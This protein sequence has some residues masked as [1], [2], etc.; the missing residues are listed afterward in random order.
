MKTYP[1]ML[2]AFLLLLLAVT[3]QANDLQIK[4]IL[5]NTNNLVYIPGT[6]IVASSAISNTTYTSP[7]HYYLASYLNN[8]VR[9]LV[10][11]GQTPLS[12]NISRSGSYHTIEVSQRLSN[13]KTLLVFTRGDWS[14]VENRIALIEQGK[15]L[16]S[17]IPSFAHGL[18]IRY[19]IKLLLDYYNDI[20]LQS[21]MI[22]QSGSHELE[23]E[24]N[25]TGTQKALII[26]KK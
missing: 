20:D 25:K 22:I 8:L 10:H 19:R 18:G 3:V 15:F 1:I 2:S 12:I 24:S 14:T 13:S 5:N 7:A 17:L 23:F 11:S 9:A 4:L 16:A 26:R 21:N 6:G